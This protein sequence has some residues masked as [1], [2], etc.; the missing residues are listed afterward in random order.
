MGLCVGCSLWALQVMAAGGQFTQQ[1]PTS[2][3]WLAPLHK[4]TLLDCC[5]PRV[6]HQTGPPVGMPGPTHHGLFLRCVS[7]AAM[8]RT[9]AVAALSLCRAGLLSWRVRCSALDRRHSKGDVA[10][11]S[12]RAAVLYM[13]ALHSCSF[14]LL[15]PTTA[16]V[17]DFMLH[18]GG[19]YTAPP[20]YTSHSGPAHWGMSHGHVSTARPCSPG[21]TLRASCWASMQLSTC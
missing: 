9:P 20:P 1:G 8:P 17:R 21:S 18:W 19:R 10:H 2:A 4:E 11:G 12:W 16:V 6:W 5:P 14:L 13:C 15:P 7:V 3:L